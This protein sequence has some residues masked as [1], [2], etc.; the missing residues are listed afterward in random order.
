MLDQLTKSKL[1]NIVGKKY[2]TDD[3]VELYCYSHD[4]VSRAL[5]WVKEDYE[6]K[7][8]L[9]IKP[10]NA[11]EV[12]QIVDLANTEQ[13]KII[14][15]GAGTSY[16]GQFLPIEG[17]VILD[18]TRMNKILE[19]NTE[20]LYAVVQPGLLFKNLREELRNIDKGYWIPCNPGSADVCTIGGMIANDASGESAIKYGT[21]KDYVLSLKLVLGTGQSI[22]FGNLVQKTVSGLDLLSLFVGSEGTL[23]IMT[24]ATLK[25]L[26]IPQSFKTVIGF[27]D[28]IEAAVLSAK[29]IKEV[30]TPMSLELLDRITIMGM[31]AYL[32]RLTPRVTIKNAE[33]ALLI[34]LDGDNEII[35]INAGKIT[36]LLTHDKSVSNA[37]IFEGI[38]HNYIWKAR[39]GAGP[40]LGR[41]S[42]SVKNV[43]TFL[44]ASLDF[45]VPFS[46]ITEL[47]NEFAKI[48]GAYKIGF[49]RYGHLGDGNVHLICSTPITSEEDV[50]IFSS[51][52]G[53]LVKLAISLGGSVTAEHG[54]GVWKAPYLPL[55]HGE[56]A[57]NLMKNI[58]NIF[59]PNNVLNPGKLYSFP[60]KFSIFSIKN[61]E[62]EEGDKHE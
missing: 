33:A 18:F 53:D 34:R 44:P 7:A 2:I 5:S 17:G 12:K 8:D 29:E 43:G 24:E 47:M 57:I 10:E 52:Q 54:C 6:L 32:S 61:Y 58:K 4:N 48:V 45:S 14:P 11:N 31:N 38:K 56:D 62:I 21:T 16:G 41:L 28:S 13:F 49:I 3:P 19:I 39:D 50:K 46:K 27:F 9:V 59:D 37:E 36:E 15:R 55:E 35:S 60:T 40:S 51:L 25:I 30:L 22:Q 42:P 20:D 23:G 26:P 1:I